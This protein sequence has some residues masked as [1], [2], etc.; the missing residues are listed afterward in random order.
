MTIL[1]AILAFLAAATGIIGMVASVREL[2]ITR[3]AIERKERH[4]ADA[5]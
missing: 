2:I 4:D 5:R 1:I 3:R